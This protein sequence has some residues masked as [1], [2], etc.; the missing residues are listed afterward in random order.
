VSIFGGDYLGD[1]DRR[2]PFQL[3]GLVT[4]AGLLVWLYMSRDGRR[5]TRIG[6]LVLVASTLVTMCSTRRTSRFDLP[7]ATAPLPPKPTL[8]LEPLPPGMR[9]QPGRL[10]ALL[11]LNDLPP[12]MRARVLVDSAEIKLP[13]GTATNIPMGTNYYMFGSSWSA[14]AVVPRIDG[15][16]WLNE[17]RSDFGEGSVGADLTAAQE[18]AVA[19]GLGTVTM[20][21]RLQLWESVVAE[22]LLPVVG[23]E[24]TSNGRRTRIVEWTPLDEKPTLVVD[25]VRIDT[26][27]ASIPAL[28]GPA[29]ED[30]PGFVLVNERRREAVLLAPTESGGGLDGLVLPGTRMRSE[31][32]H[33]GLNRGRGGQTVALDRAW[34]E[35]ARLRLVATRFRGSYPFT[36]ALKPRDSTTAASPPLRR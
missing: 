29:F 31:R 20:K 22:T 18:R 3:L 13:D 10:H 12:G 16:R 9:G 1:A 21:G 11:R 24:T 27:G 19:S 26:G 33:Y 7:L 4:V 32:V 6:G 30:S 2:A 23:Q 35:N 17:T 36:L 5:R 28:Q 25:A 8:S 34:L 14:N 15:V